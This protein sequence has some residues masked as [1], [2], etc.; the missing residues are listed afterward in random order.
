MD[1][2]TRTERLRAAHAI[3]VLTAYFDTL[4]DVLPGAAGGADLGVR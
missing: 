4:Q 2:M 3:I 1:R